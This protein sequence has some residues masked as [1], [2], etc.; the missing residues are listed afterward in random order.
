MVCGYG[1]DLY[2]FVARLRY[3]LHVFHILTPS[4]Q[5]P[6]TNT[7]L[8]LRLNLITTFHPNAKSSQNVKSNDM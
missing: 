4:P 8:L 2:L 1:Q 6:A 7:D 5:L 3:I